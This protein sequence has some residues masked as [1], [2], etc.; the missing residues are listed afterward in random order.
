MK[1]LMLTAALLLLTQSFA[2]ADIFWVTMNTSA[3]NG[4]AGTIDIQFNPGSFPALYEAGSV[5]ITDFTIA[6]GGLGPVSIPRNLNHGRPAGSAHDPESGLPERNRLRRD[7]RDDG[8]VP[9]QLPRQRVHGQRA[10]HSEQ[11]RGFTY[12]IEHHHG[13]RNTDWR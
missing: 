9:R 12:R 6:G 5:I 3:I 1:K 8:H 11:S 13:E 7:F 2:L 4:E 10:D